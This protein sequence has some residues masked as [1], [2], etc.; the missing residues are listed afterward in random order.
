MKFACFLSIF[1]NII[2]MRKL[3]DLSPDEERR[4][5]LGNLVYASYFCS[6]SLYFPPSN[7]AQIFRAR[8]STGTYKFLKAH[9]IDELLEPFVEKGIVRRVEIYTG[10]D[11]SCFCFQPNFSRSAD[12][13]AILGERYKTIV[14]YLSE[15]L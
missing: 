3:S 14:E 4:A 2:S 15:G 8:T 5:A 13:L 7:I 11:S 9:K 1:C 10:P 6:D 12:L